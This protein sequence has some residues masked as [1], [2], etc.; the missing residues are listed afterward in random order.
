MEPMLDRRRCPAQPQ[1]CQAIRACPTGAI[2]YVEDEE[3]PLGGRIEFDLDRCDGCGRR[4]EAC[5][6][7]AIQMTTTST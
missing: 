2:A 1:M 6:G 5:C 7:S 4:A 3:E